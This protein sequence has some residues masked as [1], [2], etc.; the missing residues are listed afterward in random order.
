MHE[1]LD[2]VKKPRDAWLYNPGQ[3]RVRRAPQVAYDNPGTAADNM[4]TSDQLD[5][6]NGAPDQYDWKL[7]GKKEIFVPYNAYKLQDPQLKY[8]D[9]VT[10]L[11]IN[12]DH[13]RYELHR[14]WVVEATLRGGERHIYKKRVFYVDEDSW[15]VLIVDQYDNRDQLWRVSEGH[16]M[17]FYNVP[18][19]WTAAETHTDLQAGRY[20]VMGLF[21]ESRGARLHPEADRGRLHAGRPPDRRRALVRI[22]PA[23]SAEGDR[24]AFFLALRRA[25]FMAARPASWRCWPA[26]VVTA[27]ATVDSS[28]VPGERALPARLATTSLLLDVSARDG[29]M[30][31]VG[32][33]G[34]VLRSPDAGATWTQADVPTRALLT[35]VHLHDAMRGWAVGHDEV[36]IRTTDGGV[37]WQ[38]VH[39]APE[40]ERPLLDVWFADARTGFAVGAYGTLLATTDGGDT[41]EARTLVGEDD[42]H[43]NHIAAAADGTLYIAAEA[44]HLY[45]SDDGGGDVAVAAVPLSGI[46]LRRAAAVRRRGAR[47][48]P[49][50][51]PVPLGGSRHDVAAHR[52]EH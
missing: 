4:R 8:K 19:I 51:S 32:E 36:V 20:L 30:V 40:R 22:A 24:R 15:Q 35:G 37:T 34:H 23:S 52:D 26:R 7:V 10:P 41:W 50:R 49:A 43:L 17:N 47:D 48:G 11:H 6:F 2:Q 39:H 1:T 38:R 12:P 16:A 45:R 25:A 5:M 46:V 13:C 14:V 21:N 3:R 18:T 9:I 44:G 33:R 42:F 29:L 31:A 28:D 27:A